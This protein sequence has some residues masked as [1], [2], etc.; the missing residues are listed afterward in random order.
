MLKKTEILPHVYHIEADTQY[1]LTSLFMRPQE[2]YESPFEE[3]RGKVFTVETYMDRYVKEYDTFNYNTKWSGFNLPDHAL[4]D[5]F[6]KFYWN[7]EPLLKKEHQLRLLFEEELK[8]NDQFYVIGT[9]KQDHPNTIEHEIAHAL[10][11]LYDDYHFNVTQL[12]RDIPLKLHRKLKTKLKEV[13]YGENV[14]VDEIQA[15]LA[16]ETS[17]Y[18]KGQYK[19]TV[20][21]SLFKKFRKLFKDAKKLYKELYDG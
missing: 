11:Y 3:I 5:F 2:F 8:Y 13:G 14:I 1:E 16:V 7:N 18:M 10:Y 21:L 12:V 20:P 9:F 19:V 17:K 6:H 4:R 15:H